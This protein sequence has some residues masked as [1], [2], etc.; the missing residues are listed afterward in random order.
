MLT[1]VFLQS[2]FSSKE[3]LYTTH[4][5]SLSSHGCISLDDTFEVA[6]NIGYFRSDHEWVTQY[7]SLFI[8]LNETG[9]ELTWKFTK[10]ES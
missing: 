8:V 2:F 9:L 1:S 3:E 6:A 7:N 4:M 5:Q 10:T